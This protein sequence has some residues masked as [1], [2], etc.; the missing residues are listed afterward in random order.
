MGCLSLRFRSFSVESRLETLTLLRFRFQPGKQAN[1]MPP[2]LSPLV[3]ASSPLSFGPKSAQKR[4]S[5]REDFVLGKFESIMERLDLLMRKVGS[6]MPGRRSLRDVLG[7]RIWRLRRAY[8][9]ACSPFMAGFME[10]KHSERRQLKTAGSVVAEKVVKLTQNAIFGRCCM[11]PD[12]F[13]NTNAYVD[14]AKFER[15]VGKSSVTNFELQ[16]NDSEGFLA[17]VETLKTDRSKACMTSS[18]SDSQFRLERHVSCSQLSL[19]ATATQGPLGMGSVIAAGYMA[20]KSKY[21]IPDRLLGVVVLLAQLGVVGLGGGLEDAAQPT[22]DGGPHVLVGL[23]VGD[24]VS[25]SLAGRWRDVVDGVE[26]RLRPE[27][28]P[29][30]LHHV[31]QGQDVGVE[32]TVVELSEGLPPHDVGGVDGQP[33]VLCAHRFPRQHAVVAALLPHRGHLPRLGAAEV[34][35]RPSL[36]RRVGWRAQLQLG[37]KRGHQR[38][39]LW[40]LL[41]RAGPEVVDHAGQARGEDV[42][43]VHEP[44]LAPAHLQALLARL[45]EDSEA[46]LAV[47][48]LLDR[49]LQGAP[50]LRGFG[51]ALALALGFGAALAMGMGLSGSLPSASLSVPSLSLS[52]VAM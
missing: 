31:R 5:S 3:T 51:A 46:E 9:F 50:P 16:I 52:I 24:E 22:H 39:E 12:K 35:E 36:G 1:S 25:G 11:N 32:V 29:V 8:R 26:P 2:S 13:R 34:F 27:G 28:V 7:A 18:A 30:A 47:V 38:E 4:P 17:F 45:A 10:L 43:A 6:L 44:Q 15:A 42:H 23:L 41:V 48:A 33:V 14:P 49:G 37:V 20:L 21:K 40:Q 19:R